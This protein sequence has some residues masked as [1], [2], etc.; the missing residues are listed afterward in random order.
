MTPLNNCSD[1]RH[2]GIRLYCGMRL[3]DEKWTKD[4]VPSKAL[5]NPP[6]HKSLPVVHVCQQ[7]N[8]EFS[9]DEKNLSACV[10]AVI[11]SPT[12]PDTNQFPVAAKMLAY[13]L[14]WSEREERTKQIRSTFW[15]HSDMISIPENERVTRV[16]VKNARGHALFALGLPLLFNPAYIIFIPL[17]LISHEQK[18]HSP[19]RLENVVYTELGSRINQR[20]PVGD[21]Q[22]A[23][24]IKVQ[25]PV[26]RYAVYQLPGQ[27]F[28][29]ILLREYVPLRWLEMEHLSIVIRHP[30]TENDIVVM[31]LTIW[32]K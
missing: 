11:N 21:L 1:E 30:S 27:P 22:L 7:C 12:R 31:P 17:I 5:L 8:S 14:A 18:G 28:V 3:W 23:G 20:M 15:G 19:S 2:K 25:P 13:R 26:Y 16:I 9:K 6:Y 24:W 29:R 32:N 10:A 4:H